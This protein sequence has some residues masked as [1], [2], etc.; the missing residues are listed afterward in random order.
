MVSKVAAIQMVS[1][2]SIGPNLFS[3]QSLIEKAVDDGA[4]LVV[5][6]ECF[7]CMSKHLSELNL[8]QER[9]GEGRVQDFVAE[10]AQRFKIWIVGGTIPIEAQG[11]EKAY[12]ASIIW[13]DQGKVVEHYNKIHLFDVYLAGKDEHYQESKSYVP[14]QAL[15]VVE[16]PFG[17]IG[18]TVCY[19][20]RF[21]ELYRSLR[22]KGAE[23]FTVPAAFTAAT[24]KLHWQTLLS[25]RA[26][27]NQCY[28][29]AANQGGRHDNGRETF[30][31]SMIIGPWGMNLGCH[32]SDDGYVVADIDLVR[33]EVLREE[34]P[35]W[36]HAKL[37]SDSEQ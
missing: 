31:H 4:S 6:P 23:I 37:L 27:E 7:S 13:D 30:G 16:T 15:K 11:E 3:A 17:K 25:A 26:I 20:L 21:P 5:L 14:G 2:A 19:D 12:A 29:I 22:Q 35:V 36:Q 1:S 33:L 8:N 34:F 24:G 18:L 28:V 9:F 32:E 10:M